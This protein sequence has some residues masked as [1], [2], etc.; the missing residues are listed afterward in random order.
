MGTPSHTSVSHVTRNVLVWALCSLCSANVLAQ[1]LNLDPGNTPRAGDGL[2]AL[3]LAQQ[4]SS[5]ATALHNDRGSTAEKRRNRAKASLRMVA[6]E[7]LRSGENAGASGSSAVLYG[8]T[9]ASN[10]RAFDDLIDNRLGSVDAAILELVAA[11][12]PGSGAFDSVAS[13]PEQLDQAL[14]RALA[15]LASATLDESVKHGGWWLERSERSNEESKDSDP[16][17][18]V[19]QWLATGQI[20]PDTASSLRSFAQ[21]GEAV[22]RIPAAFAQWQHAWRNISEL[23]IARENARTRFGNNTADHLVSIASACAQTL[24]DPDADQGAFLHAQHQLGISAW[25]VRTWQLLEASLSNASNRTM[26][27]PLRSM[28]EYRI[29]DAGTPVR[30]GQT[31]LS[32]EVRD[33]VD[34]M[35]TLLSSPMHLPDEDRL[36][37][38]LKPARRYFAKELNTSTDQLARF[39]PDVL[40]GKVTLADPGLL[41]AMQTQRDMIGAMRLLIAA[42]DTL[43]GTIGDPGTGMRSV[44]PLW[45]RAADQAL[46]LSQDLD[47]REGAEEAQKKFRQLLLDLSRFGL[48]PGEDGLSQA[49]KSIDSTWAKLTNNRHAELGNT[50]PVSRQEWITKLGREGAEPEALRLD[51]LTETMDILVSA[52]RVADVTGWKQNSNVTA[53]SRE[54]WVQH[55]AGWELTNTALGMLLDDLEPDLHQLVTLAIDSDPYD[56]LDKAKEIRQNHAVVLLAGELDAAAS[57]HIGRSAPDINPADLNRLPDQLLPMI[58]ISFGVP[59][60]NAWLIGSRP[61]IASACRYAEEYANRSS[62]D[63]TAEQFRSYAAQRAFVAL[64]A[65]R[66]NRRPEG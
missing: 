21:Q 27:D 26:R 40:T 37:R 20:D 56:A 50:I 34:A 51:A 55:W 28:I 32:D 49:S 5:Q 41:S 17:A 58:E 31:I 42:S 23:I 18:T 52:V 46:K 66:A 24:A 1:G 63:A 4:L 61:D 30:A 43:C 59:A 9:L 60:D 35:V 14:A 6:A 64:E 54:L 16:V 57:L 48:L 65:V 25:S 22:S 44:A 12:E 33:A 29:P 39:L 15:P 47:N 8:L 7:L 38:Q 62:R 13:T 10:I 36:V 19:N 2:H 53:N 11:S 3:E 45:S